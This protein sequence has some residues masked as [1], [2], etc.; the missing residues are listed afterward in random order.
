[1]PLDKSEDEFR[2]HYS[3]MPWLTLPYN[4]ERV[5]KLKNKYNITSIPE[6]V[7]VDSHTGF[8][9]TLKGRKDIHEQGIKTIPDWAKLLELNKERAIKK[10]EEERLAE[11]AR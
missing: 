4:D 5:A 10:A 9:V 8:L 11:I 6:L 7:I 2:E 1:V 3:H